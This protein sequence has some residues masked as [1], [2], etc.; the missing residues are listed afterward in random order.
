ISGS[1]NLAVD[2]HAGLLYHAAPSEAFNF[3]IGGA[4]YHL[5]QP[6]ISFLSNSAYRLSPRY[7]GHA[8]AMIQLSRL[9]NLLPSAVVYHQGRAR[10]INAGAYLQ[11]V[12]NDDDYEELT[13]FSLGAWT[14]V[15]TPLP[16]AVIIGARMDYWN[17]VLSLSYD[18]NI[19]RLTSASKSR[20]AYEVALIYIGTFVTRGQRRLMMPCPQL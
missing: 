1:S 16:D 5:L 18:V 13:A 9:L 2:A 6:E 12:L 10:Q 17:F 15:A 3:Y 7:V 14:R 11:F 19:S 8:G 20:G 4:C